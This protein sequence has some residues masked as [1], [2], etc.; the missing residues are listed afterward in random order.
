MKAR[1]FLSIGVQFSPEIL[2]IR[3]AA[4]NLICFLIELGKSDKL[5]LN[6]ILISGQKSELS[7]SLDINDVEGQVLDLANGILQTEWNEITQHEGNNK[8]TIDYIR[9]DGY[10]ILLK[11]FVE[12][13]I[14]FWVSCR[15]GSIIY[16]TMSIRDF[17]NQIL[18]DYNWYEEIFKKI[19]LKTSA[20]LG[21][22]VMS[23]QSFGKFYNEMQIKYPIGW[24]T[25]F[26]NS[27]EFD[28]PNNLKEVRYEFSSDGKY[29]FTSDE[30]FMKDKDAYFGYREKLK[31]IITEIK[32]RVPEFNKEAPSESI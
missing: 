11:F 5:F 26:S 22:I 21:T 25:Y 18:F 19:V 3:Q 9:P 15:I 6:P 1:N 23:N 13:E 31:G 32:Q 30:D 8:P 17:S 2:S 14:A 7:F 16:Q 4:K 24:I 12:G 29:L 27:C 28:I 20:Y 10:Q